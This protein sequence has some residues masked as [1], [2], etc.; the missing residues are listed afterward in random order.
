MKCHFKYF[1]SVNFDLTL[2]QN[3][4]STEWHRPR[5]QGVN[6]VWAEY[7]FIIK[8]RTA[9]YSEGNFGDNKVYYPNNFHNN[10]F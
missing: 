5:Q 8:R 3:V 1:W 4:V 2:K 7:M 6:V 10:S 9:S